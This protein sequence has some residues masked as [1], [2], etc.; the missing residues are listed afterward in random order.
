MY[1]LCP[2]LPR[3]HDRIKINITSYRVMKVRYATHVLSETMAS[4]LEMNYNHIVKE[5]VNMNKFE[6]NETLFYFTSH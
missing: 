6:E 4:A 5:I 1:R 2:K 3:E